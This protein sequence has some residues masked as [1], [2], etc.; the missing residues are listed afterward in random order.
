M[1]AS[2]RPLTLLLCVAIGAA[3]AIVGLLPWIVTGMRLPLQNAWAAA[4]MP[5]DMP[6]ALL[7]FSPYTL[8]LMAGMLVTGAAVGGM[9]ARL[10]RR[11]L[12]RGGVSAIAGGVLAVQVVV[13]VQTS[14]AV[15]GGLREDVEGRLYFAAILGAIVLSVLLGVLTLWLIAVA[16]RAGAVIGF[17][18]AALAAE[19]WA[20]GLI[21]APFSISATPFAL[22]L[23]AALRWLPSVAVGIAIAWGGLRTVGGAVAA[24]GSLLLLWV[25]PATTSA[26]GMAAGTRVYWRFPAEMLAAARGVFVSALMVPSL[27]L[28]PVVLAV[29]VA[30]VGL[31]WRRSARSARAAGAITPSA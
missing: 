4:A 7:P 26:I 28:L 18:L 11:R 25:A 21:V 24:V 22:W 17:T 27:S 19:Q 1:T 16:P 13:V 3:A 2:A 30:A 14:V 5:D 12:P 31:V 6:I 23:A 15:L 9:A 29:T 10:L 8:I 20:A